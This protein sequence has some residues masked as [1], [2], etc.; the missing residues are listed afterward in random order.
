[1]A[2]TRSSDQ[3][4][5]LEL[6]DVQQAESVTPETPLVLNIPD[7]DLQ[8]VVAIGY[9]AED[10]IYYPVGFGNQSGQIIIEALPE[11]T[12][13]DPA[14]SSRSL[15][16]NKTVFPEDHWSKTRDKI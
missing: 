16:V 1:M 9:D 10:N 11:S 13:A 3:L 12:P 14:I 4:D 6:M 5:I 2:G 8:D 7:T 15:R